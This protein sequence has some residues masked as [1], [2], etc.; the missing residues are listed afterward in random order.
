LARQ[1]TKRRKI[2]TMNLVKLKKTTAREPKLAC[3]LVKV[4]AGIARYTMRVL[5]KRTTELR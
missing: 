3:L 1:V 2:K 4:G 5:R